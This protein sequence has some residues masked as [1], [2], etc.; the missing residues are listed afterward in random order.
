MSPGPKTS[1]VRLMKHSQIWDHIFSS[2]PQDHRVFRPLPLDTLTR[3]RPRQDDQFPLCVPRPIGNSLWEFCQ[4]LLCHCSAQM[5]LSGHKQSKVWVSAGLLH[6][7]F[8]FYSMTNYR[9]IMRSRLG[10]WLAL[11]DNVHKFSITHH[12]LPV[13]PI[14]PYPCYSLLSISLECVTPT[15]RKIWRRDIS[16]FLCQLDL[17]RN[18]SNR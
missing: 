8:D 4:W 15:L 1:H 11:G 14:T 18:H 17:V 3:G 6:N 2:V 7:R 16:N 5:L 12:Q 13:S 9:E 10:V